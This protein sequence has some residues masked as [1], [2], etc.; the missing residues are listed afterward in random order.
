MTV[1][2]ITMAVPPITVIL[3]LIIEGL[4]ALLLLQHSGVLKTRAAWI[5]SVLLLVLALGLRAAV[6]DY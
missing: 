5:V 6:F 1:P 4:C 2:P 3:I